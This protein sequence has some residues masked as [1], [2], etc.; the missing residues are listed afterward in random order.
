MITRMIFFCSLVSRQFVVAALVVLATQVP[1]LGIDTV[2]TRDGTTLRGTL[3]SVSPD[4]IDIEVS[5][6]IKKVSIVNLEDLA[7]D[8]EPD[9]LR[10]ARR[11]LG[12]RDIAGAMEEL[13]KI[14]ADD[15]R[16]F[17]PRVREDYDFVWIAANAQAVDDKGVA[18][19]EKELVQFLQKNSRSHRFYEGYELLGD[20]RARLGRFP[21]AAEA[22]RKLDAGPP[23]MRIRAASATAGLLMQQGKFAEAIRDFQAAEKIETSATDVASDRQ[24]QEAALGRARCLA[25]SGKAA[26]GIAVADHVIR[27]AQPQDK[28]LLAMAYTAL[29]TCQKAAGG[30]EKE[31]DAIISFL[32]VDLVYNGVPTAH[33]EALFH[34][35]ALWNATNQ[36]ERGREATQLLVTSYPQS[37]WAAKLVGAGK[38]S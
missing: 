35:V 34:L 29:G 11:L 30:K 25:Q 27:V 33:A 19:W 2:T 36:L 16:G 38:S 15:L 20:L 13:T 32:T 21:E 22:Y 23:A 24:K 1:S 14:D 5:G 26:E 6:G 8:G 10:G 4:A 3:V 17:D 7:I 12:R 9:T 31:Q 37:P 18:D 28:D